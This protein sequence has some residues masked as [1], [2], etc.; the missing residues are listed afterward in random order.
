MKYHKFY[1]KS[2]GKIRPHRKIQLL[3]QAKLRHTKK[4]GNL[5][6]TEC[7]RDTFTDFTE[8]CQLRYSARTGAFYTFL[9]EE[10]RAFKLDIRAQPALRNNGPGRNHGHR[11]SVRDR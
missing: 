5:I 3:Y 8:C 4:D 7:F 1:P 11:N 6:M 2:G 9:K 10:V